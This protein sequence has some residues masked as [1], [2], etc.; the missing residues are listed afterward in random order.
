MKC[1]H[2]HNP[3]FSLIFFPPIALM[4]IRNNRVNLLTFTSFYGVV[5]LWSLKTP[6]RADASPESA[7]F[8]SVKIEKARDVVYKTTIQGREWA[9]TIPVRGICPPSLSGFQLPAF[10]ILQGAN[11][12]F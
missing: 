2:I 12:K 1:K 6:L 7:T 9:N 10:C 4:L 5:A 3:I 8:L 11:E